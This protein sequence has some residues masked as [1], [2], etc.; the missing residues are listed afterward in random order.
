MESRSHLAQLPARLGGG[1]LLRR[2]TA[3]DCEP[4]AVFNSRIHSDDGPDKPDE[5]VGSLARDMLSG[6]HPFMKPDDFTVVEEE[7]S[8]R[9]VS[10][11]CLISQTW[12]FAGI[13]FKV[14]RPEL[15]AT[16]PG[17]RDRGLVRMQFEVIHEWS[18][19]RGE[20]MQAITG[21]P[22]YYRKF[23]YEMALDLGGSRTLYEPLLPKVKDEEALQYTLRQAGE[24][25]LEFI[26]R[27]FAQ[28][29]PRSLVTCVR[30]IE[31]WRFELLGRSPVNVDRA[32]FYIVLDKEGRRVGV[33]VTLPNEGKNSLLIR[34][35][36][37]EPGI[38]NFLAVRC[39]VNDLWKIMKTQAEVTGKP[40][41]GIT[42]LFAR[43]HKIYDLLGNSLQQPRDPYAWYLRV[44]DVIGF[45]DMIRPVL[46]QRLAD[47]ACSGF[48]GKLTL[49]HDHKGIE[50]SFDKGVIS[51]V[52]ASSQPNWS[53]YDAVFPGLTFLQL[54][55]GYRSK[56]ELEWSFADF[57]TSD[58][59][60]IL[61]PALFPVQPSRVWMVS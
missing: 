54:L 4:L 42:F 59:A 26:A 38:D 16:E 46:N 30:N 8:G 53:E 13:P 10:S 60:D 3:A 47:S 45:I 27:I 40:L 51:S 7:S 34:A 17:F 24:Q 18:R 28:N 33:V 23:G 37:L 19:E 52:T 25:D 14:G 48:C 55:F 44:P 58:K 31:M 50:I 32:D 43:S 36:E 21:I 11:M 15:V 49:M 5:G 6:K 9:I 39:I 20:I 1:L 35:I 56:G 29:L 41:S 12:S 57:Y 22:V 2:S 61:L